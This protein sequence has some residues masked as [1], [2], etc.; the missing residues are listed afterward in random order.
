MRAA[1]AVAPRATLG[2]LPVA[3]LAG[4]R[5]GAQVAR[6]GAVVRRPVLDWQESTSTVNGIKRDD[7]LERKVPRQK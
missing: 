1:A 5:V 6:P 2:E 4:R 7:D 3:D